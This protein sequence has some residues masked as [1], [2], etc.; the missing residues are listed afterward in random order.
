MKKDLQNRLDVIRIEGGSTL[1]A[2]PDLYRIKQAIVDVF[3]AGINKLTRDEKDLL[4]AMSAL[5]EGGATA[6]EFAVWCIKK[7]I[8]F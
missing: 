3:I 1:H 6:R 7:G 4:I 8:Q 2:T 5:V